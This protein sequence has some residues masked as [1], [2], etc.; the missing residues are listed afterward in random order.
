MCGINGIISK[1]KNKDKIIKKMDERIYH[2]GPDAEGL[3]VDDYLALGQRRLSIIDLKGGNQPIYNEDKSILVMYNG[4]IYNYQEL[5]EELKN[6]KFTTNSDT[7]VLVHGYEEWGEEL[8][9]KLRGMF[10]FAI[11]DK[12]KK[13]VFLARDQ[14]G[15]K[16]LYYYQN[17]DAII[18][19]M[20][21]PVPEIMP[22]VAKAAGAR[23][24][25]TGRSD[26]PNQVNNVIA[27][28]GIFKGALEGRA[29]QITEDMKL[30]AA[31][32]IAN[33]VPDDEVSDVNIL[34]EAFDPRVADVVS[35]AVIDHIEK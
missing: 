5:K 21:N 12:N 22:D 25:G 11:Y 10:T 4:E 35:K 15:I 18:F 32:A 33:L 16:P 20:A 19:A 7:E 8:P 3:Y 9:K 13:K 17:K 27:F 2:R 14:F 30:A 31:L 29:R 6:H 23:V 28:P 34:P 1:E 24:V 26:F